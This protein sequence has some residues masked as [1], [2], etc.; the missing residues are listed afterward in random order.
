MGQNVQYCDL[1]WLAGEEEEE[2]T[3]N[4]NEGISRSLWL[5]RMGFGKKLMFS[6]ILLLICSQWEIWKGLFSVEYRYCGWYSGRGQKVLLRQLASSSRGLC[7][8]IRYGT[9]LILAHRPSPLIPDL[10]E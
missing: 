5:V 9:G 4:A 2:T 3:T 6:S 8:G 7:G 10:T 1:G